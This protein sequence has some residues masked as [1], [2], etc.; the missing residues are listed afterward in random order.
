MKINIID[1]SNFD[2]KFRVL[3]NKRRGKNVLNARFYM[4]D[5]GLMDKTDYLLS[6]VLLKGPISGIVYKILYWE[7]DSVM[8]DFFGTNFHG[9]SFT[10]KNSYKGRQAPGV[11]FVNDESMDKSF[12]KALLQYHFNFE[13]GGTPSLNV[14]VQIC[15]NMGKSIILLDIYD[16][17]GFFLYFF[18]LGLNAPIAYL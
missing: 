17:R 2:K 11:I 8:R 14:R 13:L 16:D 7:K 10:I 4:D 12:F 1:S 6:F 3:L 5:I 9:K 18:E 15:F